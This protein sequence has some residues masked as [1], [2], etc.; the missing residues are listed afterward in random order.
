MVEMVGLLRKDARE[1]LEQLEMFTDSG[2][3][4]LKNY[5]I[6]IICHA[7]RAFM[8]TEDKPL[9]DTPRE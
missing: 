5:H 9:P 7:L 6:R 2:L 3:Y 4:G 8:N 1:A